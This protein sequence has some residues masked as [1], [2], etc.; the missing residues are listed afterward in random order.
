MESPTT[1]LLDNAVDL[2]FEVYLL[3]GDCS[4]AAKELLNSEKPDHLA[5]ED[6]ARLDDALS[7]TYRSLQSTIRSIQASRSRRRTKTR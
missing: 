4:A 3:R 2:M 7:R 6:C 1:I 5:I